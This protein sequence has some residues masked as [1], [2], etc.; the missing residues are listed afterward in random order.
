MRDWSDI[1]RPHL[2]SLQIDPAR[3]ADI[4]DEISQ[5]LD[6]RYEEVR[7]RGATEDEARRLVTEELRE[8]D[9]LSMQMSRLRQ[10]HAPPPIGASNARSGVLDGSW[11]DLRIAV[12]TLRKSPVFAAAAVLTLALAIGANTAIFSVVDAVLLDPLPFPDSDRLVSI[13]ATA[14]GSD[15]SGEFDTSP[16]F[17]VEYDENAKTLEDLGYYWVIQ[18]SMRAEGHV[19]RLFMSRGSPSLFSTLRAQPLLGRLP[20][21]ADEDG[22]VVVLSHWLWM[23]W[24]GGDPS[25]VGR[26]F[27]ISGQQRTVVGVM[28]PE[29]RF[30][31][32][33]VALWIH[34][35]FIE[36]IR[37][38]NFGVR[39]VGRLAPG[40]DR[41]SLT[42]ELAALAQRLPERFGGS[43]T[44]AQIIEHHR[45]VVRS[46]EEALV[47]DVKRPLWTL[48]G[49]VG[50][51]L[52][53][54]CANVANLLIV[55]AASRRRDGAVRRA[56]GATRAAIIRSQLAEALVLAACGGVA[57]LLLAWLS[58]P[59]I[60]RV[61]PG[62]VPRLGAAGMDATALSFCAG[63]AILAALLSGLLP[64]IR[65]SNFKISEDLHDARAA[66]SRP[67]RRLL[68]DALVVV[69]T[70]AALVLLIGSGLLFQSFR[71][72]RGVDPG[73]DTD[74]I[75]TFQMAPDF[76][77]M[78]LV[79]APTFARFHYAFMD[80]LAALPGVQSVGL[81]DML[82]LDEGAQT[83]AFAIERIGAAGAAEP[84]LGM[85]FA[86]GDYFQTMGI[87]LLSGEYFPRNAELSSNVGAIVSK[88]AAEMLWP[89]EGPLGKRLRPSDRREPVDWLTVT[90]VVED[91][92]LDDFRQESA[93]A[94]V[95]LPL[96]GQTP[97]MW[98]VGTPAYV[99]KSPRADTIAPDVRELIRE[100]APSAPMYRVFTMEGLA[101][102]TMAQLSFTMLAIALAAALAVILGAVGIY[103]TL[104]Y[105][106]SQR[107]RE[108]GIRMAL[109][110]GAGEVRRMIVRQGGRIVL[111][112]VATG[113][114][115]AL[116]LTRLLDSMLFRVP[117]S[118]ATTFVVMSAVVF[119]VALLASYLPARR[120]SSVDPLVSLRSE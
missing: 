100:V 84:L 37:P 78:G 105:M 71:E 24:F 99:V 73:F 80:R 110:A 93:Q 2:K 53:I 6:Q 75:F 90:G 107:T 94:M 81:V 118:D 112:G 88:S 1:V 36:P 35:R 70:S 66:G 59:L 115:A 72:L 23:E 3:E 64:A 14:P 85:T 97:T 5:H 96:V 20:T 47:G 113:I 49:I 25:V 30:P 103:G 92:M 61:V 98:I 83:Q 119:G 106:V 26:A 38:G 120:A 55:R 28:R 9:A 108:I 39:L 79:D 50:I 76:R 21:E 15:L 32:E 89:G 117:A 34:N 102:R 77:S 109:G 51:V 22:A 18:S 91:V 8:P 17:Y 45:P 104:S 101:A 40:A 48:M 87:R 31:V 58:V 111:V 41:A 11:R 29:F 62:N 57:G 46:L 54:A 69:Q 13:R 67:D 114:V 65:Y 95:Y 116:F 19:E 86:G 12:R 4:V 27:D 33:Q 10:A 52:V 56:L 7:A 44:Y 63:V 82:P 16:E 60:V 68:R 74:D 43:A 42:T